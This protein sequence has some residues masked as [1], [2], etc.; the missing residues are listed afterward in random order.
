MKKLSKSKLS[1]KKSE[2]N[3]FNRQTRREGK[4]D[5]DYVSYWLG[6][7]HCTGLASPKPAKED[8]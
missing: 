8:E 6:H 1:Y 4:Y 2:R 5:P 3:M 7:A